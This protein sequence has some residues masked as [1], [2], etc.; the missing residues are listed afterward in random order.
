MNARKIAQGI[1][2]RESDY[3]VQHRVHP[4]PADTE[5]WT[6]D[7]RGTGMSPADD[8]QDVGIYWER[9]DKAAG[10]RKAGWEVLRNFVEGS[11]PD[12]NGF[13]EA[14]GIFICSGC[15]YW[16][17]LVPSLPR[18]KD[19]PDEVPKGYPDHNSDE[20]RYYLTYALPRMW[21]KSGF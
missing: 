7:N 20:T 16:L 9:A 10:S 3:G 5:I 1:L 19:D 18:D 14:P 2:D 4:G 6:K 8:M 21:R 13:R 15:K 12:E 11:I 17:E